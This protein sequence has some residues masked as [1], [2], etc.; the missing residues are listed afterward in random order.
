MSD[1]HKPGDHIKEALIDDFLEKNPGVSR[2]QVVMRFKNGKPVF[3]T[4]DRV[5]ASMSIRM[6]R[7][8]EQD[9]LRKEMAVQDDERYQACKCSLEN[10]KH[11]V[12][13]L[14][15]AS[16]IAF[17]LVEKNA[18]TTALSRNER[19]II[20]STD[21]KLN[22]RKDFLKMMEGSAALARARIRSMI[23]QYFRAVLDQLKSQKDIFSREYMLGNEMA[24]NVRD[25]I[26][27][28]IAAVKSQVKQGTLKAI[29]R[30]YGVA[31]RVA[32][33]VVPEPNKISVDELEVVLGE[34]EPVLEKRRVQFHEIE[35]VI[36]YIEKVVKQLERAEEKNGQA[37]EEKP[38]KKKSRRMAFA[39]KLF[40]FK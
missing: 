26:K 13:F 27:E 9:L 34:M 38:S 22:I 29:S 36:A 23:L 24:E 35:R 10:C 37:V 28:N 19:V 6:S 39:A 4:I 14:F 15:T 1:Q 11:L 32:G 31:K 5:M 12:D 17:G 20:T 3:E 2:S 33:Q 30:A 18:Q 25:F 8:H 21:T 40:G 7:K 16:F